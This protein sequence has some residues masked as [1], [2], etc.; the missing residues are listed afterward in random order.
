[1]RIGVVR[2]GYSRTGGAEAYLRRFADGLV[3]AGHEVVLFTEKWPANEWPH[4][5]VA[6]DS[7]SPQRFADSLRRRTP[8]TRCD[9]LFSLERLWS[10]DVYRA[11]DGV[12]AAWLELRARQEPFWKPWFRRWN[13][14]HREI[15]ALE[16]HLFSPLGARMVIANSHMVKAEIERH[17]GY[18]SG[19]IH[20]VHN[21]VPP[22][23]AP[24]GA[25]E[26][27]RKKLRLE[28]QDYAVLFAGSG[29]ERKGLRFAIQAVNAADLPRLKL[30]VAG[31]GHHGSQPQSASVRYLGPVGD[32]ASC[33]AAADAFILPT[34][35]D[36]FSNACLEALAAGLPVIT[37]AHNGFSEIIETGVEGEVVKEADDISALSAAIRNWE[38]PDRR[39]LVRPRLVE[40]G[41]QFSVERNVKE[42]LSL[43]AK[44]I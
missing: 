3:S 1:M 42:T 13:G 5:R 28:D 37:T 10:C 36:A 26:Q 21:G 33:F 35:Y 18:P 14:K 17:F 12:H 32:M 27:L 39:A 25:R 24:E 7:H 20:V 29:W 30:L 22:F 23:T 19:G 16:K 2:R 11:G 8:G 41:A 4:E 6:I 15:L 44:A 9:L 43:I 38:D 34:L 40:L 31:R